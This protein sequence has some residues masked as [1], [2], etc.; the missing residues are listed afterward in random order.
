MITFVRE[1]EQ[2]DF[3]AAV[4]FLASKAGV[5]LRYTDSNEGEDRRRRKELQKIV[6]K[7]AQWYHERLLNDKD[8]GAARS[9]LRQRGL[10]GE[11]VRRFQIGWAPDNWDSLAK[12]L[13]VSNTDLTESGLGFVNRRNRQQDAFRARI[14]FP[15]NDVQG[16]PVGFGGRIM[17]G[18]AADAAKYKNSSESTIYSKSRI[19]YSLDAAKKDIVTTNQVLICEGYTDVIGFSCAGLQTA[20]ATC[21]TSLTQDHV[22]LLKRF[23]SKVILAFDA[24]KA[25]QNAAERFYEWEK[26]YEID[27]YVA[28]L[29]PGVDPGDLG[30]KKPAELQRAVAEAKPFLAFR[31]DRLFEKSDATTVEGRARFAEKALEMVREHPDPLVQDQYT[32]QIASR[33]RLQPDI[34]RKQLKKR[35][36]SP[37]QS[38]A[39][40]KHVDSSTSRYTPEYEALKVA[41]SRKEEIAAVLAPE[42]FTDELYATAYHHIAT[43][44][45]FHE[46]IASG[47]PEVAEVLQR[48]SVEE[49]D[50]EAIDVAALLWSSYIQRLMDASRAE[51]VTDG[52]SSEV[53]A[54]HTWF[55]LRLEELR[56]NDTQA[57]AVHTL[58]A[59]LNPESQVSDGQ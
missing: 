30:V 40:P 10:S 8:A 41:S 42:L 9:Y 29:P 49:T 39:R 28:D 48:L 18:A 23:T 19:L 1:K 21:G 3:V 51:M 16:E 13:R 6:G 50:A 35:S 17:P 56:Q 25:G 36:S 46:A 34:L 27:V 14:M 38:Q 2:L 52:F 37:V 47:G 12:A 20:V 43:S 44:A 58:V 15:I 33:A 53:V 54:Q 4:E 45:T 26:S 7:A 31:I 57:E 11:I 24:D 55:R 22:K 32:M 5:T 59:W